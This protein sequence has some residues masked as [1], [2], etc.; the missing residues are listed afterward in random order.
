[1]PPA[2]NVVPLRARKFSSGHAVDLGRWEDEAG[3]SLARVSKT[4]R[5]VTKASAAIAL[6]DLTDGEL[7]LYTDASGNLVVA[8]RIAGV[9]KSATLAVA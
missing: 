5:L 6:G 1:M 7:A 2:D 9:L 4:G 8:S 3:G